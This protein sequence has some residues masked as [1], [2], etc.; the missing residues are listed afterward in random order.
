MATADEAAL[1]DAE[2]LVILIVGEAG[3]RLSLF[4]LQ[5]VLGRLWESNRRVKRLFHFRKTK[6][7]YLFSEDLQE[8]IE[9][10]FFH[11]DC[12]F[13]KNKSVVLSREGRELFRK[14]KEKLE[15]KAKTDREIEELLTM[16]RTELQ[17]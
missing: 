12:W 14:I 6:R 8:V 11:D 15:V 10:P 4:R 5:Q 3:G 13:L 2:L 7:G 1:R 16:L 9:N 17:G